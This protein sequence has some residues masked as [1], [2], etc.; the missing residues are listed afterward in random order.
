[1]YAVPRSQKRVS[2]PLEL[3]LHARGGELP[4]VGAGNG[5]P[6]L[7]AA[8]PSLQPGINTSLIEPVSLTHLTLPTTSRV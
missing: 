8:E 7:L 2:E 4:D 6:V 5:T 3:R 1:M